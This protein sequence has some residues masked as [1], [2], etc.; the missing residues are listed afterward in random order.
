MNNKIGLLGGTF[1][2]I[3]LGHIELGQQVLRAFGLDRILYVLSA[4]PPHK[5]KSGLIP[6][7]TRWKMLNMALDPYHHLVPC[8]IEMKRSSPSWTYQT[9]TILK[10]RY[11]EQVLYFLSGSEGFLK[12]RTWR[13]YR[14]LLSAVSFIVI[15]RKSGHKEELEALLRQEKVPVCPVKSD[16]SG[17][18]CV[19]FYQYQ[20]DTLGLS[21]TQI[22][23]KISRKEPVNRLIPGSVWEFIKE[24]NLYGSE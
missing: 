5:G 10:S 23:E 20:S 15:L 18:P 22:R 3:H 11:P 21:S 14:M 17:D 19:F 4:H 7:R 9:L 8:D 6:A 1:N 12:I 24:N 16:H 2:P 13:N